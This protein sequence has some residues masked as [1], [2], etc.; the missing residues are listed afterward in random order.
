MKKYILLA[1]VLV[2]F[3]ACENQEKRY[4]QQSKEID[5]VKTAIKNYNDK[6]Y[7]TSS[8][9]D[10]AKTFFNSSSK[11]EFKSPEE[12]M[13]YHKANDEIY[14]S[15]GFTAND[16]EYEMVVTD[17]G[18]TWVNCW[19]EWK[20]TLAANNKEVTI[21]IH[22]TYQFVDAKV[23]REVGIWD[24]T[25]VL[26]ALQEI[27]RTNAMSADEKAIQTTIDNVTKA[28]NSNDKDV[29][30]ANMVNNIIRT[31]NGATIAKT[32]SDYGD[33]MEVYHSAF[34][35]FRVNIDKT[36]IVGNTAYINWTCTGTNTGS[37]MENEPTNKKI[38]THGFSVWTFDN[39]GKCVREDAFYDNLIVFN[40]LGI[41][42]PT[43]LDK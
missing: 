19:L 24:P 1:L 30:Y 16:P 33:F 40:Q 42:P 43:Q 25:Q 37:F 6:V 34:P 8:Y 29:M 38:E 36:V 23:V 15:R 39:E 3:T 7:D 26:L 28:W 27:E 14:S 5:I 17:D 20:G 22:L 4:T 18:E 9:A 11:D 2:L 12:T 10:T 13:A 41:V 32:Q 35:D 21:P 31:G